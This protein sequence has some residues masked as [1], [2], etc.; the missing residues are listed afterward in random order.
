MKKIIWFIVIIFIVYITLIFIKPVIA[1][2]IAETL[3]IKVFNEKVIEIKEKLDYI[4]TKIPSKE[5]IEKAYSGAKEKIA[6]I[7]SN[8]DDIRE[9]ANDIENKYGEVK[10]FVNK[11]WEKLKETKETL[12]NLQGISNDIGN[13]INTWAVQ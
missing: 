9:T 11:A 5:E 10:D 6:D 2:K 12:N 7:K 4:S 1:N 3:W 13:L 8:I